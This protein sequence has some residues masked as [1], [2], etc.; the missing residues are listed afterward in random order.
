MVNAKAIVGVSHSNYNV[1][2]PT[3]CRLKW[4]PWSAQRVFVETCEKNRIRKRATP[5][6]RLVQKLANETH[7]TSEPTPPIQ[8]STSEVAA[9]GRP[10]TGAEA[11]KAFESTKQPDR[12][13]V[14]D[15]IYIQ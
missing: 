5:N 7:T 12:Q 11:A 6:H 2:V 4:S 3:R 1:F 13:Q 14:F 9:P 8:P 15:F 10:P